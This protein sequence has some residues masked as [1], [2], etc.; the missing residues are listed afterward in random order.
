MLPAPTPLHAAVAALK[1]LD[2]L[3][4]AALG[5]YCTGSAAQAWLCDDTSCTSSLGAA[6]YLTVVALGAV[7]T[8]LLLWRYTRR[9][10]SRAT[11]LA[12]AFYATLIVPPLIWAQGRWT[13]R[14]AA[15]ARC[16]VRAGAPT[17]NV[18]RDCGD[19]SYGCDWPKFIASGAS[20]CAGVCWR[21]GHDRGE[22][23]DCLLGARPEPRPAPRVLLR[24]EEVDA[25]SRERP[26]AGPLA[27]REIDVLTIPSGSWLSITPSR[28]TTFSGSPQSRQGESISDGPAREHPAQARYGRVSEDGADARKGCLCFIRASYS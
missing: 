1:R 9:W 3:L 14:P 20:P 23:E 19:P 5:G 27:D 16:V 28:T 18:H 26:V 6:I 21:F 12:I 24:P 10:W 7:G 25:A 17:E 8:A 22:R 4:A 15:G 13:V 2:T 11:V